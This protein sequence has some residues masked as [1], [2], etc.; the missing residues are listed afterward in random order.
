MLKSTYASF[1]ICENF[2]D[3]SIA[4]PAEPPSEADKNACSCLFSDFTGKFI[5]IPFVGYL[6][7][8]II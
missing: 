4:S 3:K 1:L 5:Y 8:L 6:N 7:F 2:P